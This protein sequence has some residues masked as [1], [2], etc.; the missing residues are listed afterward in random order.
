MNSLYPL[1]EI[2][3]ETAGMPSF[4]A[5]PVVLLRYLYQPVSLRMVLK[6]SVSTTSLIDLG[7]PYEDIRAGYN[8]RTR[9]GLKAMESSGLEVR[10]GDLSP[11][12]VYRE[13]ANFVVRKGY[14]GKP[15]RSVFDSRWPNITH[16]YV[17]DPAHDRI[18]CLQAYYVS[19]GT[20]R[21]L[22]LS[23]SADYPDV[24]ADA[25]RALHDDIIRRTC[26]ELQTYDLGG[27]VLD[28]EDGRFGIGQFKMGFGGETAKTYSYV[29]LN[30]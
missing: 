28:P 4:L 14:S 13:V 20:M 2:W 10:Y 16:N 6:T 29:A 23:S 9:R 5:A 26:G 21:S 22:Y 27:V 15:K 19:G 24:T 3:F 1:M 7:R 30:I 11:D 18:V 8:R 17:M 12:E 25:T